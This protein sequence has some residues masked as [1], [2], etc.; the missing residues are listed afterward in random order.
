MLVQPI[1]DKYWELR[2]SLGTTTKGEIREAVNEAL[3]QLDSGRIRVAEKQGDVWRVNQWIK[4][5]VL[6]SFRLNEMELVTGPKF[7]NG[8]V[9]WFDKVP[10]KFVGWDSAHFREAGF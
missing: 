6:L 4:K 3:F 10:S 7:S 5:A 9:T 2:Q 1:I 8:N